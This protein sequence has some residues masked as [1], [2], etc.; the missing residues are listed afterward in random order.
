M[1]QLLLRNKANGIMFN[2]LIF[3]GITYN[4]ILL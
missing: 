4:Q 1:Y 3:F 2:K